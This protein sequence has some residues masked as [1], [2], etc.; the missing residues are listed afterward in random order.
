MNEMATL[1]LPLSIDLR[2]IDLTKSMSMAKEVLHILRIKRENAEAE[3]HSIY[4]HLVL[5]SADQ[6]D[7]D[8][9]L[10][11]RTGHQVYRENHEASCPEEFIFLI[12]NT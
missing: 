7:I 11:R 5:T 12:W 3:F 2:D 1:F 4:T 8:I 6:L 9:K 10:P